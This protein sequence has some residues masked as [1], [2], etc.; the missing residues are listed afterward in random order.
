VCQTIP[1]RVI[2]VQGDQAE[3]Q[4]DGYTGWFNISTQPDV[5]KD[6]YVLTHADVVV[7]IIGESEAH[8]IE[9]VNRQAR[10]TRGGGTA[11]ASGTTP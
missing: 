4:T 2:Q 7:S 6:D 8:R 1:G 3:I 5:K 9:E 10:Q 11:G